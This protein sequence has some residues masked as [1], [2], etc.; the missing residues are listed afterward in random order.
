MTGIPWDCHQISITKGNR[1]KSLLHQWQV[2]LEAVVQSALL[3]ET[4]SIQFEPMTG[5]PWE[6]LP[7]SITKGNRF[8]SVWANDRRSLRLLPISITKG[9]RLKSV[10]GND[11]CSLRCIYKLALLTDTRSNLF[12]P[13][14]GVPW[15]CL[16]ISI[17]KETGSNLFEPMTGV[18]W[19][20]SSNQHN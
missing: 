4:G 12:E 19:D 15:G 9:N 10:W 3:T 11:R 17:I 13:M 6:C 8:K 16:P 18:P 14:T 5:V 7:I 20:Y 2:F 1:F